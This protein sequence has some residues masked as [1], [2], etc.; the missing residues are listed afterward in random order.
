M[1]TCPEW[2][3]WC[4]VCGH[5][6]TFTST[7]QL[8]SLPLI[9]HSSCFGH[10]WWVFCSSPTHS[11]VLFHVTIADIIFVQFGEPI[12]TV[13]CLVSGSG[14]RWANTDKF[15]APAPSLHRPLCTKDRSGGAKL[16]SIGVWSR[17]PTGWRNA[18]TVP[19]C[20]GCRIGQGGPSW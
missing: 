16:S 14:V 12:N 9:N 10:M 11:Y 19:S 6:H 4:V 2:F 17:L 3:P 1:H 5:T 15:P 20:S 13:V 8:S 18:A 7:P